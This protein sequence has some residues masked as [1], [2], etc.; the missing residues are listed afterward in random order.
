M[1][2]PPSLQSDLPWSSPTDSP[3]GPCGARTKWPVGNCPSVLGSWM[4]TLDSLFP[5][6]ETEVPDRP[7]RCGAVPVWDMGDAVKVKSQLLL[8]SCSPL[9]S[10]CPQGVLLTLPSGCG[11]FINVF[12]P[13]V[14]ANWS[15]CEENWSGTTCS[16]ILPTFYYSSN[17]NGINSDNPPFYFD[18][19]NLCLQPFLLVWLEV[20]QFY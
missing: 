2:S 4:S 5:T 14:V 19:S 1:L 3:S 7:S 12:C 8:F 18:I 6:G 17:Y 15:F 16:A 9:W 11:I 13:W 20:Y 10:L